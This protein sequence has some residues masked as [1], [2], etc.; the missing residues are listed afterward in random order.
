MLRVCMRYGCGTRLPM[1]NVGDICEACAS[2][3]FVRAPPAVVPKRV[4]RR[5]KDRTHPLPRESIDL[6]RASLLREAQAIQESRPALAVPTESQD[7]DDS[8]DFDLVYPEDTVETVHS[9]NSDSTIQGRGPP[10]DEDADIDLELVYPEDA[11]EAA[12]KS[13]PNPRTRVASQASLSAFFIGGLQTIPALDMAQLN[14]ATLTNANLTPLRQCIMP[15]CNET[16]TSITLQ[17][18]VN[19]SLGYWKQRKQAAVEARST[20]SGVVPGPPTT[21]AGTPVVMTP[22][23][24]ESVIKL[25]KA[26][27]AGGIAALDNTQGRSSDVEE[28]TEDDAP[29]P[30]SSP[31]SK[32]SN[33]PVADLTVDSVPG[34]DSDLTDLS[35]SSGEESESESESEVLKI[36]IPV[37]VNHHSLD[38]IIA[39][40]PVS[41]VEERSVNTKGFVM[42]IYGDVWLGLKMMR[43]HSRNRQHPMTPPLG[44]PDG[45][46]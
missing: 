46:P 39:G 10:V 45:G 43:V 31:T 42:K 41:R 2:A 11:A 29:P 38:G 21:A 20:P 28:V 7:V 5:A 32:D 6:V 27:L 13:E 14:N 1:H 4:P 36:T 18:C 19:C 15:G 3:G 44:T 22:N 26:G 35:S 17:R 40:K 34:W 8:M 25:P 33:G 24:Q 9:S 12:R 16:L 30:S 37:L 23:N